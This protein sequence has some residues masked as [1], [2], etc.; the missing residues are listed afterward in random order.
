MEIEVEVALRDDVLPEGVGDGFGRASDPVPAGKD[1]GKVG[2]RRAGCSEFRP[3]KRAGWLIGTAMRSPRMTRQG[4]SNSVTSKNG[5]DAFVLV[6]VNARGNN[7]CWAIVGSADEDDGDANVAV[8][9]V[10]IDVTLSAAWSS[11]LG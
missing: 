3:R 1:A 8:S 5:A 2:I 4:S 7:E 6:S 9:N 11:Q 10:E